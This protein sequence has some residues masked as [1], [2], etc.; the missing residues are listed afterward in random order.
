MPGPV[1]QSGVEWSGVS[2]KRACGR[3]RTELLKVEI[4]LYVGYVDKLTLKLCRFRK[5]RY[6]KIF[7]T[8]PS[9]SNKKQNKTKKK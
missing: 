4:V 2:S 3:R 9:P 8:Q 6:R 1:E 5:R 7:H